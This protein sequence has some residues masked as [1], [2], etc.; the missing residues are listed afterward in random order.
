MSLE[1]ELNLRKPIELL[2][3]EVLLNVYHTASCIKKEAGEFFRP[4][5]LTTVQ[6]NVLVLLKHQ[7]GPEEG[8][9]QA[10]L[11]EMMLVNRSNMTSLI[12]RMEKAELVVRTAAKDRRYKV[13]KL[14]DTGR[15]LQERVEP[16]YHEEI[17]KRMEAIE[18]GEQKNLVTLL[19]KVRQYITVC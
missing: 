5:G 10:Q 9:T 12:D 13:I 7:V 2:P 6:Y 8:L 3:Q 11:S 14:T 16:L 17:K 4:F 15:E 1:E 18:E 19:E